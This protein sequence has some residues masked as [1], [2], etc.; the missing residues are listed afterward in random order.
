MRGV[1][2]QP[3]E[4]HGALP[5][6]G[7]RVEV[8]DCFYCGRDLHVYVPVGPTLGLVVVGVACPHCHKWEAETLVPAVS[9][10]I[11]VRACQRSWLAWQARR[12]MRWASTMRA[13]ARIMLVWPY[14][15]V[16]RRLQ[17][18]SMESRSVGSQGERP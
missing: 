4:Q 11:L 12:G 14:R 6:E 3:P 9:K 1:V 5:D 18:A 16:R 7:Y 17:R 10:P 13:Y 15:A 2:E 8:R